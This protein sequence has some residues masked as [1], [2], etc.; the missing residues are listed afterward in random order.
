MLLVL[1]KAGFRGGD[2]DELGRRAW[3][4]FGDVLI[5]SASGPFRTWSV[6]SR[7]I[8]VFRVGQVRCV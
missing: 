7:R 3:S 8:Y 5:T 6:E 4:G 1:R 2:E